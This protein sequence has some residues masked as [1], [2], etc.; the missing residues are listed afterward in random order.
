MKDN[1]KSFIPAQTSPGQTRSA[2][3]P[4]VSGG[5][6]KSGRGTR[7][8]IGSANVGTMSRRSGEVVEMA[9]RRRLDF[10]CLQETRWRG[11]GAR[12]L[13]RYKFFW[14]GCSEG[15]SGV[16]ILVS[17]RWIEKVLEVKRVNERLM[18]LKVIVGKSVI[19]IVSV[20]APQSGMAMEV[21]E[22]FYISLGKVLSS[23]EAKEQLIVCGDMN[24]HVGAQADGYEGVHGGYGFGSRNVEGEMLLEFADAMALVVSNTCYK[25]SDEKLVTYESGGSKTVVDYILVRRN[26]RKQ[27]RNVTVM[28]GEPCL[29]QH[30]LLVCMMDL[31]ECVRNKRKTFMSK[32]RVWKLKDLSTREVFQR[33]V[34]DRLQKLVVVEDDSVDVVWGE[35]RDCLLDVADDICGKTKGSQRHSQTWW[36]NAEVEE[37][38]NEKRRLYKIFER[39]KN[40]IPVN[41]M[42]VQEKKQKYDAVKRAVKKAVAKAKEVERQKFGEMLDEQDEK[43]AVFRAAKQIVRNNRDIV[44]DGCIKDTDGKIV[45]DEDKLLEV[46]RAY[47]D[48]L[49]NE[50]F[51]WNKET[52]TEAGIKSGPC[53]KITLD[54]VKAA[55]KKMKCNK[56]SGPSGVVVDMLKAAGETGIEWVAD[57]CN[58][59]IK[60][61]RIPQDW[62]KSWMINIYKGK[63]DALECGS[64][65]GIR[66]LEHAMKVLE[67]V[68][69]A[70]VR[71]IV[72]I[73][74]MQFGFMPGRGT[75]DAIFIV[76]Q[77]QEKYLAKKKDLWMAFIDLEKAFDRVPRE[78]LW[79][80][81]RSLGVDEWLVAVIKALYT[82]VAT[83]VKQNGRVSKGFKVKVGVHQ[84]SGLSPLLFIIVLEALSRTFRR[85]LPMELFYADDLV[86]MAD[87]E[88]LLLEAIKKWKAGM[89]EKGLR[90]NMGKTKVMKCQVGIGSV[91]KAG[92]Y[93][94]GV[95]Q[96]GVGS[97]SI[98]CTSCNAWCHK[99]C[100]GISGKLQKVTGFRCQT[101]VFG[102]RARVEMM[103]EVALGT[104]GKLECVDKFRYLGDMIEAGGG[105]GEASRA[106]VR[107][108]WAKFKE[109]APIL[110]SRGASLKVKGKVYKA[111]VQRVLVYGSETWAMK[112]EDTHR[113]ERAER[114][115]VRWMCGVNLKDRISSEELNKR[116]GVERVADVVRRGR[117]RWFGHLE[118]KDSHD[119]ISSCRNIIIDGK[120]DRGRSKKTWDECVKQDLR[121]LNLKKEW[122]HDKSKWRSVI[123]GKRPTCA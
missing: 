66:L 53:E 118:R 11:E 40:A 91:K 104:E 117:L 81:L 47:Y 54:E 2:L 58:A 63:G 30:R 28:R 97:N 16:G 42:E 4:M 24:G 107:S 32:C 59:V 35:L 113:L 108:A 48:K 119:W 83:V 50:E 68:I 10:C 12:N 76:R 86:L 13:G 72:Q 99:R 52:L 41:Q 9:L 109:L 45:T 73:D 65:R 79:W 70:R 110:T 20:Y 6:E 92:E 112:M 62:C 115:M 8:R 77:L 36:W 121:C 29:L 122:A 123:G 43:G 114:M 25:K 102:K 22:E 116:L 15:L 27:L 38:I 69:E 19:N 23:V 64:Y 74:S 1:L 26:E 44:G 34:E 67:K 85:G 14:K 80:A 111:C 100:S 89:E 101:C 96:K 7:I 98:M 87:T 103:Q 37:I 78:V 31:T 49:S 120:R 94:C 106:R 5:S 3:P 18:L 75:T 17:E 21:K 51:P 46:W 84:G 90:V 93:P 82:D 105:V 33:K 57:V 71:K 39:S 61:G 55:V 56:A 60:E 95:C 88:E